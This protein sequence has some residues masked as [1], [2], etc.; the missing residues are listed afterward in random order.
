MFSLNRHSNLRCDDDAAS[1]PREA[2]I[3]FADQNED[4]PLD[5]ILMTGRTSMARNCNG[6][7]DIMNLHKTDDF[8]D[9]CLKDPHLLV[10]DSAA[11]AA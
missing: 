3:K 1:C 2:A 8:K 6:F 4:G 10:A 7:M 11:A 5:L 9:A